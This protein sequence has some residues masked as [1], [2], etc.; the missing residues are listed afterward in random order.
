MR[1][2]H[3]DPTPPSSNSEPSVSIPSGTSNSDYT[4]CDWP[5]SILLSHLAKRTP[6]PLGDLQHV[7]SFTLNNNKSSA[8]KMNSNKITINEKVY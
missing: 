2:L 8:S 4:S 5:H 7:L 1:E 6:L 3:P